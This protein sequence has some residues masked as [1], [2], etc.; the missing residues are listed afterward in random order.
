MTLFPAWFA[1]LW[2]VLPNL[3][4]SNNNKKNC[5][6]LSSITLCPSSDNKRAGEKEEEGC[7]GR[8]E[9]LGSLIWEQQFQRDIPI[10][11]HTEFKRWK[12]ALE[13]SKLATSAVAQIWSDHSSFWP[14]VA[15]QGP[16]YA[17]RLSSKAA[18]CKEHGN[19]VCCH[20][21]GHYLSQVNKIAMQRNQQDSGL[22]TDF[23]SF[24]CL[25]LVPR[26]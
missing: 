19:A 2:R 4:T 9:F 24:V 3:S 17:I 10:P 22:K 15:A 16:V 12:P 13:W 7:S 26:L 21:L 6:C 8:M 23:F 14:L 5:A 25:V 20:H 11:N 18:L 1:T